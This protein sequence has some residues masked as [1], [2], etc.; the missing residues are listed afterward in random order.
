MLK[1]ACLLSIIG[2]I[3]GCHSSSPVPPPEEIV[4]QRWAI[5]ASDE[6]QA[7]GLPDLLFAD[8]SVL[9]WI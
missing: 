2:F 6:I 9:C 8:L 7:T 3:A 5:I 1:N 4:C